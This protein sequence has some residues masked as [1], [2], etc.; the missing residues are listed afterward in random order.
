MAAKHTARSTDFRRAALGGA[1]R[2]SVNIGLLSMVIPGALVLLLFSYLP[3]PLG[4]VIAFKNIKYGPN[5]FATVFG[6]AWYGLK[7]FEFFIRTPYAWTITRNTILYNAVFIL[8]GNTA[9]VTTAIALDG[10]RVKRAARFYQNLM[11]LP[12]FFS[13]IVISTLIFSFLSV[14]LGL[15]NKQLFPALGIQ[16]VAWYSEKVYWPFILVFANLWKYT[17]YGS[18]VYFAA[19]AGIDPNY[20]EASSLDGA[21]RWQTI[22]HIMLPLISFVIVIQVLLAIGRLFFSDFGLFYQ[23]PLN[24][25][26]LFNV[27]NVIDTYVYRTLV[28][29][30]DMGMS[31]AAGLYQAAVGFVLVLGSN[32]IVRRIDPEKSLF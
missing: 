25:G 2:R 29:Q 17:G 21:N 8:L 5:F 12:W 19:I 27:T 3:M 9:A 6:S 23:V 24:M 1:G 30:G 22:R 13:W 11:F 18:V 26:L 20:F 16:P 31:A 10:L 14:D 4:I 28:N 32:L 15:L 7:N